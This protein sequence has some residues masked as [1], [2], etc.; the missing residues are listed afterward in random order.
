M[1]VAFADEDPPSADIEQRL[2]SFTDLV[3]TA[4]ANA[5][6]RAEVTASRARIVAA[7][8]RARRRI[9]R[10]LHDGAQQRLV[11][12]VLQLNGARKEVPPEL[13]KVGADLR[14][15][16]TG[17]NDA[18][19]ELREI[20]RGIHPAILTDGGLR[21]AL[22]A[23][24]RRSPVQASVEVRSEGRLP[25]QV[26]VTAYYVVAEAL[27]NAARHARASAVKIEAHTAGGML[28][29]AIRD[30]GVGGAAFT[31]GTGLAGTERPGGGARRPDLPRQPTWH[32]NEPARKATAE[33]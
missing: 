15:I 7:A 22:R 26:E 21:P 20:A 6:A 12:L 17:L 5:H 31:G 32:W 16:E 27:T 24:A 9:E 11:T 1:I 25:E 29:I 33:F 2:A 13:G 3:A 19:G 14:R 30:D 10:D 28:H 23:L 18:L 4:I 8:D